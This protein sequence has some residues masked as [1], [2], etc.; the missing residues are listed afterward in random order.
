MPAGAPRDTT[1]VP[2]SVR[3]RFLQIK[4]RWYF[5]NG[6]LAFQDLGTQLSTKT[7]NPEVIRSFVA[8]A[9]TRGWEDINIVKGTKEFRR[10]IWHEASLQSIPVRGYTPTELDEAR[11]VQTMARRREAERQ[12]QSSAPVSP[13]P[14]D[15]W[16][17][18]RRD[19]DRDRHRDRAGDRD[20]N[21]PA[22]KPKRV[23]YGTLLSHGAENFQFNPQ[24]D[25]SY[26]VKLR[27]D[28]GEDTVLWGKDLERAL[29]DSKSQPKAGDRVGISH[30]GQEP[31]T[32]PKKER[33][34]TGRVLR[35]YELKTHRNE[36]V[37]ETETFFR[38]RAQL[39][40]L[41][42]DRAIDAK[43]AV[44]LNP[45]LAGTYVALR[46]AELY[47]KKNFQDPHE[48]NRFVETIRRSLA[49]DIKRGSPLYTPALRD[50]E[51]Q[52]SAERAPSTPEMSPLR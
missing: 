10:A 3:D 46:G 27:T 5:E 29:R 30:A 45:A 13:N 39:A 50:R 15:T 48:Q 22:R 26:Y 23:L 25:M 7:E 8:I 12:A 19:L 41:V 38:E 4:E 11:L 42:R 32:V 52:R 40:E 49:R 14:S 44:D 6:D 24:E 20:A 36:W 34:N 9:N 18:G 33:D 47:A 1:S 31:V 21:A 2:D 43:R 16:T 17:P 51:A 37:I 28:R 35:E